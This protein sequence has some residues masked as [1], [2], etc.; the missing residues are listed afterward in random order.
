MMNAVGRTSC[1]WILFG[2]LFLVGGHGMATAQE[3]AEQ[4]PESVPQTQDQPVPQPRHAP[5]AD[6][7]SADIPDTGIPVLVEHV[8]NDPVGMRLA[9]HLKETF[10]KSSLFRLA[11]GEEKHLNLRLI[12]RP[13][14]PERPFLGS[15]Y[16]VVWRYVESGDVLAYYLSDRLGFVDADVVAQEAEV[17]VAETDKVASR[18]RYLLE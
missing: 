7:E 17:L 5:P 16:A 11:G 2:M 13:Q 8:G 18:F 1:L 4:S 12:T 3:S 15:A 9:L 14:F 10:Q 6:E